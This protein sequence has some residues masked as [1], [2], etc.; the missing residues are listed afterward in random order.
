[1]KKIK[2]ERFYSLSIRTSRA[3]KMKEKVLQIS[4][5]GHHMSKPK[6]LIYFTFRLPPSWDP[7]P[8]N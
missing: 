8:L 3:I 4:N 2:L 1:M 7:V 6:V 5:I